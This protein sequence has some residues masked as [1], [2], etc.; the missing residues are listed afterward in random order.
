MTIRLPFVIGHR[1]TR[2]VTTL[3]P[4]SSDD[5]DAGASE[6]PGAGDEPLASRTDMRARVDA[7]GPDA[8]SEQPRVQKR[9]GK[10]ADAF[11][12]G[13]VRV[14]KVYELTE[15]TQTREALAR[16]IGYL[17]NP[18]YDHL[19]VATEGLRNAIDGTVLRAAL[20]TAPISTAFAALVADMRP[21]IAASLAPVFEQA[22]WKSQW[23]GSMFAVQQGW[24]TDLAARIEH[25][26]PKFDLHRMLPELHASVAYAIEALAITARLAPELPH[27]AST[28]R[29]LDAGRTTL[30]MSTTGLLLSRSEDEWRDDPLDDQDDELIGGPAEARRRLRN[31][32]ARLHPSLVNRLDGAWERVGRHGPDAASQAANS[33]VELIDWTLRS[34]APDTEVLSWHLEGG[35]P[36]AELHEGRPTRPLRV[37]F[38]ARNR[39]DA[40]AAEMYAKGISG[41]VELLQGHKHGAGEQQLAAVARLLPTVEAHLCFL[42]L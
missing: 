33:L 5:R 3:D 35:R 38:I 18:G 24:A 41:L 20:D 25:A 40:V 36:T 4:P 34:A 7:D 26:L 29:L 14:P 17:P 37:R 6:R 32:L 28:W 11:P 23:V 16:H 19:L 1:H 13:L 22:A 10:A 31:E 8:T 42:L 9:F 2:G 15:L 30:G 21:N 27:S 39:P 12:A